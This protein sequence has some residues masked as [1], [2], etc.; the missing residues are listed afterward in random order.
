MLFVD[1]EKKMDDFVLKVCFET[2]D[3]VLSI[4]GNSGSGKSMTLKCIAGIEKPDKGK[5]VLNDR[6]LFDSEKNINLSPQ[7]RRVGYLF[8]EYALFPNMSVGE[9][10]EAALRY[11]PVDERKAEATKK[12]REFKIEHIKNKRPSELSGGEQQRVALARIMANNPDVLL[13]DEPF[14]S[15]DNYLKW[16]LLIEMKST[17]EKFKKDV[18]FVSHN[19]E[20]VI[21]LSNK[22]CVLN[23]GKSESVTDTEDTARNL[24]T[25]NAAKLF[26]CKNFS[27]VEFAEGVAVCPDWNT[28]FN[29][30]I[31]DEHFSKMIEKDTGRPLFAGVF[32]KDIKL[33]SNDTEG[34]GLIS[35]T[36]LQVVKTEAIE[37][38]ILHICNTDNYLCALLPKDKVFSV[39][40]PVKAY[41]SKEK[42]LFLE[43]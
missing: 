23:D 11:L 4:L 41:I 10:I 30:L 37:N 29:M 16:Q 32:P 18:I 21:G 42:L 43:D 33:C 31:A 2:E 27:R 39:N 26:G 7:K 24:R 8:Q 28:Q 40:E 9:N 17:L 6:I 12:L 5:I 38:V 22:V 3:E 20:E 35:C 15:L 36:V 19:I 13:L 1:I 34:E 14:S 25:V